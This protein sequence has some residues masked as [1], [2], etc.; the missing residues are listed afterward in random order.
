MGF[1]WEQD[2]G[3]N[4]V[5]LADVYDERASDALYQDRPTA[6]PPGALVDVGD[7]EDVAL[8]FDEE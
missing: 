4:G 3:A 5:G 8:P 7:E 6:A 2:L 1:N